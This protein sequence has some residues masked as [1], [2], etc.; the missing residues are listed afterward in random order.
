MHE[1]ILALLGVLACQHASRARPAPTPAARPEPT[2]EVLFATPTLDQVV[3][4]AEACSGQP[5]PPEVDM[6]ISP[7]PGQHFRVV[8]GGHTT[9]TVT[10]GP[11]TCDGKPAVLAITEGKG[12]ELDAITG[13]AQRCAEGA[14]WHDVGNGGSR[15]DFQRSTIHV[16]RRH[17]G[18][19]VD[20]EVSVEVPEIEPH[21]KPAGVELVVDLST[22]TCRD[23][24]RD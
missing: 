8:L 21:A 3:A 9:V 7:E 5:L 18:S 22:W 24:P 19:T 23:V 2:G 14:P 16:R 13:A 17:R 15:L 6:E 11:A 4:Q 12:P 20:T 1:L 10:V